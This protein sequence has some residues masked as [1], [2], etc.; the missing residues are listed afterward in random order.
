MRAT[1]IPGMLGNLGR[2][3][4][5]LL[6]ALLA[7]AALARTRPSMASDVRALLLRSAARAAAS[8]NGALDVP[9]AVAHGLRIGR[10]G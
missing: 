3:R 5:P 2:G 9:V 7:P 4:G 1:V 8:C 6:H 10:L